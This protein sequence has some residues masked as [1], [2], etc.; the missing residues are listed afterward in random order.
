MLKIISIIIISITVT[1][2]FL[3]CDDALSCYQV[4]DELEIANQLL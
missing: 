1:I 3:Y 2:S 4:G